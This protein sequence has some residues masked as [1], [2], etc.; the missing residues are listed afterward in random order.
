MDRRNIEQKRLAREA[1]HDQDW[2]ACKEWWR[3]ETDRN[4]VMMVEFICHD[5][6]DRLTERMSLLA[7]LTI[8]RLITEVWP[9]PQNPKEPPHA[10]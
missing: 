9:G 2:E 1:E 4:R 6:A 10:P 7:Q 5:H 3:T 8:D